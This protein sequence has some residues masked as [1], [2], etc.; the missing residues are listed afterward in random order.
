VGVPASCQAAG[1][2]SRFYGRLVRISRGQ[3]LPRTGLGAAALAGRAGAVRTTGAVARICWK[4]S[5][6]MSR[7]AAGREGLCLPMLVEKVF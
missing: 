4:V 3:G 7:D 6:D 1:R 2:W 5:I